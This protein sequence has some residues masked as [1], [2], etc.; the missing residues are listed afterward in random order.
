MYALLVERRETEGEGEEK[1]DREEELGRRKERRMEMV[2]FVVLELSRASLDTVPTLDRKREVT[3]MILGCIRRERG[4]KK[5]VLR[6]MKRLRRRGWG[7]LDSPPSLL[8][9]S[10]GHRRSARLDESSTFRR[11]PG[12]PSEVVLL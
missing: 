8:S 6:A 12:R 7:E 3:I 10:S 2:D 4:S 11:P 5:G 9:P 1:S